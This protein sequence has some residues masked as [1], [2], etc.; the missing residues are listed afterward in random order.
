MSRAPPSLSDVSRWPFV[1]VHAVLTKML[2]MA[3]TCD[4]GQGRSRH[5]AMFASVQIWLPSGCSGGT[6]VGRRLCLQL[7]P[8]AIAF[9]LSVYKRVRTTLAAA[10]NVEQAA[11]C[12]APLSL[13]WPSFAQQCARVQ[14]LRARRAISRPDVPQK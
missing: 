9:P 2:C 3:A 7:G 5:G 14:R 4:V 10:A 1:A 8:E 13:R 12:F 6:K 11:G